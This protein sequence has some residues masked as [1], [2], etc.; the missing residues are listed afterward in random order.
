MAFGDLIQ[1]KSNG[2][3]ATTSTTVTLDATATSGNLLVALVNYQSDL[4]IGT[5][6]TGWTSWGDF[7]RTAGA[8]S[9]RGDQHIYFKISDGTETAVTV[10]IASSGWISCAVHEHE[11][12]W[13]ASPKDVASSGDTGAGTATSQSTGTTATTAS[14]N[15]VAVAIGH[16]WN[17]GVTSDAWDNGFTIQ[18]SALYATGSSVS[19]AYKV[20]SATGTVTSTFS[21]TGDAKRLIAT[22]VVFSGTAGVTGS[23][24]VTLGALTS[25]ASGTAT[26]SVTGTVA[27]TLGALNSA[28]TGT[29]GAGGGVNDMLLLG[30]G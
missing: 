5:T 20:L 12:P 16:N 27:V 15:S 11:G 22:V 4:A 2:G 1:S 8:G 23:A 3:E 10:A 9:N 21:Y 14:A 29:V 25:A 19:S 17:G 13:E 18:E 26:T 6:P 30:V 28:A 7:Q 24:A